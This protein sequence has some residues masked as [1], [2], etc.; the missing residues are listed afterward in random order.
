M[1]NEHDNTQ[2][3]SSTCSFPMSR[4]SRR[5]PSSTALHSTWF[6]VASPMESGITRMAAA[7][8]FERSVSR[9]SLSS[10]SFSR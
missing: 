9:R 3:L 6:L 10:A 4:S 7:R 2:A 1:D 5:K 8:R